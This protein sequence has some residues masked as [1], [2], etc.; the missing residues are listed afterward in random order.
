MGCSKK[1]DNGI[2]VNS[3]NANAFAEL[4]G[5]QFYFSGYGNAIVG[6]YEV[7]KN[8]ITFIYPDG[9]AERATFNDTLIYDEAKNEK[10]ILWK[11]GADKVEYETYLKDLTK[12]RDEI[13]V[14]LA[15]LAA[16]ITNYFRKP[17]ALGGGGGSYSNWVLPDWLKN[18]HKTIELSGSVIDPNTVSVVAVGKQKG[19]DNI[20]PIRIRCNITSNGYNTINEN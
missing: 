4:K 8:T 19:F 16:D 9:R 20:N 15:D 17:I 5:G 2:Y 10:W 14:A 12:S 11:D 3:R 1:P 18:K 7:E 13:N 6:K